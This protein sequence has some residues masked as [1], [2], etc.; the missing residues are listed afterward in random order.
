MYF[1]YLHQIG[2]LNILAN[3]FQ[4]II[5]PDAVAKEIQRGSQQGV[6]LP[7]LGQLPWISIHANSAPADRRLITC[8]LS[9]YPKFIEGHSTKEC[10]YSG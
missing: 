9:L 1:Q 5:V 8:S 10:S 3:L 4:Q 2:R 7:N 6:E